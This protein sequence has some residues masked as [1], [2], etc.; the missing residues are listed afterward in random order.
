M[1]NEAALLSARH[2]RKE[3]GQYELEESIDRVIAGPE[4]KTR[5]LSEKERRITAYHEAGHALVGHLLPNAD[6]IHKISIIPRGQALGYTQAL[7][8]EDKFL[9]AKSEMVDDMAMLLG[10]RVAEELTF[11]D[12]TTGAASDLERATKM[13]RQMVTRY[14]MS[15]KLGPMTLGE[16]QHEVFLGRDFGAN[17]DYSQEIAYEID[18]EVRRLVDDAFS[19]ARAILEER[20]A[21]LDL[22]ADVLIE[23]ETIDKDELEALLDDRWD[24]FLKTEAEAAEEAEDAEVEETEEDTVEEPAA[25]SEPEMPSAG[26]GQ[27]GITPSG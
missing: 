14:G 20:R 7:P 18:K 21:Q 11:G 3:I 22:M 5:I 6:P 2:G 27:L 1:M 23:R 17:P 8:T 25:A 13:A 4:R 10:G 26:D 24:D 15:D 19:T 16:A 9:V 12:I